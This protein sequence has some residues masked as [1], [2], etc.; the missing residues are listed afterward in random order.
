M[1]RTSVILLSAL[2][3][4]VCAGAAE[5]A[6]GSGDDVLSRMREFFDVS[7][8]RGTGTPGNLEIE[9][10]VQQRFAASGFKHGAIAFEAPK[11]VP[12]PA[13][14]TLPDGQRVPLLPT[15]PSLFRPGN[16]LEKEFE[17]RLV[18]L[19]RGTN[20][21]LKQLEGT[22]LHGT[23][24]V[25]DFNCGE[26]WQNFLRFGIRGFLFIGQDAYTHR[27]AVG[28]VYATEVRVPRYFVA[29]APGARLRALLQGAETSPKV[30]VTA[31]PSRWE[32]VRVHDH[33][34]LIPGRDP[35]LSKDVC[36]FVAPMDANCIVPELA[37]GAQAGAN[38]FLLL[39]LLEEFQKTPPARSVLLAAVNAH[40]H[41]FLGERMLAWHLLAPDQ[42]VDGVR[43]LLATTAR[44]EEMYAREP[45]R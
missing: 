19:G 18:F 32:S 44:R 30:R 9:R 38:L 34:V 26:A 22:S 8:G 45:H 27:E 43:N 12:G 28:K 5:P 15:H 35:D 11:F 21:D 33:W 16:F 23:L 17:A 39:R 1:N 40:T 20:Q 3:V 2:L 36:V 24:A 4:R 6:A 31:E 37:V 14:L 29:P 10:R 25:M 42:S 13:A 41:C 7:G